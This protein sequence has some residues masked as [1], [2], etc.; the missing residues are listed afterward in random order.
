MLTP[1]QTAA[2]NEQFLPVLIDAATTFLRDE[3]GIAEA[4]AVKAA[5]AGA[6]AA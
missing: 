6:V 5:E 2:I 1:E 3:L 4:D